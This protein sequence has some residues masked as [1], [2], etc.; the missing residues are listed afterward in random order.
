MSRKEISFE[1]LKKYKPVAEYA[2]RIIMHEL[3]N[4][5][6]LQ[7]PCRFLLASRNGMVW[8]IAVMNPLALG[9]RIKKYHD[10]Q[11]AHQ[12][13][14]AFA[15]KPVY[16]ANQTGLRYAIMLSQKPKLPK[17]IL[18]PDPSEERDLF[19]L[20]HTLKGEVTL[21]AAQMKNVLIGAA[22]GSG[23]SNLLNLLVHQMRFSGWQLY[24]A[25]PQLHTF[26]P[27]VWDKL[28]AY[29][30][31]GK[32]KDLLTIIERIRAEI[33][34]RMALFR[35]LAEDGVSPKDI[36]A[37]NAISPDPLPRIGFL[38]DEAN[39][40]LGD[41]AIFSGIADLLR[42]GRKWG[43]HIVLAGHEWH[44]KDVPSQVNDMLQTR[45]ALS[46]PDEI[47][48]SV[49]LRNT[50]WG[51]W[52]MDKAAGCGVL[53]AQGK[54]QA[55]QFYLISDE[56]QREWF[57]D[58]ETPGPL[59]KNE[60]AYIAYALKEHAG[61]FNFRKIAAAFETL[62]PWQART[63]AEK[64]ERRGWLEAGQDAVSS[65]CISETLIE[66]AGLT[67]QNEPFHRTGAQATQDRTGLSQGRTG[68]KF[69]LTGTA[70]ATQ[71]KTN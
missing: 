64:W 28:A 42:Q 24:L 33:E 68:A 5:L 70:Q 62:S 36:D 54:F 51:K 26:N 63:L 60:I 55:M 39:T 46:T 29:P 71:V 57:T 3:V 67:S 6:K 56:Q 44:K 59:T 1:E 52:T 10:P 58:L 37:Y 4:E 45:L 30:V 17:T 27:D 43:L 19:R 8:L 50:R 9:T 14:T 61:E 47:S 13:S 35:A 21:S 48:G 2:K 53:K 20:G 69:T 40:F 25:D 41:S 34:H 31:A 16:I 65:R 38:I 12:I 32:E 22:Q 15:G 66:L 7:P 18:F 11:V 49:V 23:K